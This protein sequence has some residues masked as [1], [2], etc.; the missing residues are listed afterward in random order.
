MTET[1]EV[2][3]TILFLNEVDEQFADFQENRS[4]FIFLLYNLNTDLWTLT[5]LNVRTARCI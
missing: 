4:K 5:P 3:Q 2:V 1:S